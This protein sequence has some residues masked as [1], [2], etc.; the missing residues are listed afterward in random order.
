MQTKAN[1]LQQMDELPV[2]KAVVRNVLPAVASMLMSLIYNM[3]DKIFIGM[4]GNDYMVAAITM[5]TPVFVLFMSFGNI[6]GTGGVALI[7]RLTGEGESEKSAKVSSFCF[8]GSIGAGV[9]VAVVML[10]FIDP[11][12]SVLGASDAQTVAFTR[13]YLSFIALCCPF[14]ILSTTMSSLV[15]AGGKPTQSMIGMVAGNLTNIVL[16]P[17]FILGLGD[18]TRGAAIATLLGQVVSA[19]FYI[20]CILKGDS[21][22]SI[23]P[24]DFSAK[25]GI[26]ARVF[27]IGTPAALGTILQSVCN[28][29]INNL[30]GNYGDMA[31][32]G[33]GAAQN[34]VTVIGIFSIAIAMGI[35][36]L[37]GYQI[38]NKNKEKFLAI[39]RYAL[40]MT[41]C[42]SLALTLLCCLFT[43]PVIRAFVS[44]SEA[45]GCGVSFARIILL[46]VWLYSL[47]SVL[48]LVLQAM[49]RAAASTVVNLSRNGYVFIPLLYIMN[50]AFGMYGIVWALPVSDVICVIIAA[51]VLKRAIR[52]CFGGEEAKHG[53]PKL[54]KA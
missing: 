47:F 27:A 52:A 16:D 43:E 29:L 44:S 7:S 31:V 25:N 17:I 18:G 20:V 2:S 34:I 3:A 32:A 28:I 30:M 11:I 14:S 46:S 21:G 37:L 12:I 26:A 49:G 4:T 19:V 51:I 45:V 6:F 54:K 48:A 42:V 38:G 50:K 40:G 5:A 36:P 24:R 33:I 35:Q 41:L 23:R 15:R 53:R 1:A 8:W 10:I 9:V 39:L 22:L 13:D